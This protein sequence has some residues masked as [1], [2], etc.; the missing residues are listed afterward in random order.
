M[1]GP[2][3]F[4]SQL[5]SQITSQFISFGRDFSAKH[6]F[7]GNQKPFQS[8]T[9]SDEFKNWVS[10]FVGLTKGR[11]S[12]WRRKTV[13][14]PKYEEFIRGTRLR[15]K[16]AIVLKDDFTSQIH[17][18]ILEKILNTN[19]IPI[20]PLINELKKDEFIKMELESPASTGFTY[21]LGRHVEMLLCLY[22]K[23][24][25][26]YPLPGDTK[27]S[28]FILIM[29]LHDIGKPQAIREDQKNREHE[30]TLYV[31]ASFF[32]RM[33]YSK[34]DLKLAA[35][36]INGDSLGK[37]MQGADAGQTA[38]KIKENARKAGMSTKDFFELLTIYYKID[39]GSYTT[40]AGST[41]N[42]NHVF[43]FDEE[44]LEIQFT[45]KYEGKYQ[46]LKKELN[47]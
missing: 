9:I 27:K 18:L 1:I 23:F 19:S 29:A 6:L 10:Q 36:L 17:P 41:G 42:L 24:Y 33:G 25:E 8:V 30:Y 14:H 43:E 45:E 47:L 34:K 39:A 13:F 20:Q 31:I 16:G 38:L 40:Y 35:A 12:D 15:L 3:S 28:L 32:N 7:S 4:L 21:S 26:P 11:I 44:N 46:K 2:E 22:K 5:S 37:Y